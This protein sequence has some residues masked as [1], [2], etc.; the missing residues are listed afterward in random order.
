[1]C[2]R[3]AAA[4]CVTNASS[5][6]T[7]RRKSTKTKENTLAVTIDPSLDAFLLFL[8]FWSTGALNSRQAIGSH[9]RVGL[10]RATKS[11]FPFF[12]S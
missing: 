3:T 6:A 5:G 4:Y 1:M 8:S 2:E 9:T 7:P 10:W 12:L 11:L